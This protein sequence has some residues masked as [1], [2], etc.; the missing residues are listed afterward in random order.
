MLAA[1]YSVFR[2]VVVGNRAACRGAGAF[3]GRPRA[4]CRTRAAA[5][6]SWALFGLVQALRARQ[7][8]E[9]PTCGSAFGEPQIS[10]PGRRH[11][12]KAK[13]KAQSPKPKAQSLKTNPLR[14]E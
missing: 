12:A 3:A 5:G 4:L 14:P 13:A 11:K 8:R 9:C 10:G 6:G 2:G 1:F 7:K